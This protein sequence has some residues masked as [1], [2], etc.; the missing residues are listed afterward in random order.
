[1]TWERPPPL[2]QWRC[3]P[4]AHDLDPEAEEPTESVRRPTLA[5]RRLHATDPHRQA[6]AAPT[7]MG[8]VRRRR[9][10]RRGRHHRGRVVHPPRADLARPGRRP[11]GE[12]ERLQTDDGIREAAR[13]EIGFLEAGERRSTILPMPLLPREL[14][15]GWPYNVVTGIFAAR[16][17]GAAPVVAD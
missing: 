9:D 11:R 2:R 8:A 13:E 3:E 10:P 7:E 17:A 14:P 5:A 16:T 1:M 4:I 15:P 12:V 6:A